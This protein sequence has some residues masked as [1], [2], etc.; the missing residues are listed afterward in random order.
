MVISFCYFLIGGCSSPAIPQV[1]DITNEELVQLMENDA[2]QLIDVRTPAE[3][4]EG[5][6]EGAKNID[7]RANDFEEKMS[8]LDRSKPIAVYC[9]AGGRSGNTSELLQELGFKEIYDLTGGYSLWEAENYP[10]A[11]PPN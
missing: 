8:K 11:N 10:V 9:G 4:S 7:F 2:L 3:T 5:M 6:I 1:K